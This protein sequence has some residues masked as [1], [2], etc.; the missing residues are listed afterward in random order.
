M[1]SGKDREFYTATI[2]MDLTSSLTVGENPIDFG[3]LY[4]LTSY[5]IVLIP[6]RTLKDFRLFQGMKV[7]YQTTLLG[8]V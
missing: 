5:L 2:L 8:F 7:E 4:R 1:S 6:K 3:V